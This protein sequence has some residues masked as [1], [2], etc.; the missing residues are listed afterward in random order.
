MRRDTPLCRLKT[1]AARVG[2]VLAAL[3]KGIPVCA[4]V[5]VFSQAEGTITT[6]LT[7]AG[8]QSEKLHQRFFRRLQLLQVRL[9]EFRATLRNE[10]QEV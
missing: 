9:D 8:A 1:S 10:G 7:R 2:E 4:A 5:R 3:E 6:W